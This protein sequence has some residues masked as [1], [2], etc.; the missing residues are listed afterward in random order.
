MDVKSKSAAGS[1]FLSVNW[2]PQ[3][4]QP[5][6]SGASALFASRQTA[7]SQEHR[8]SFFLDLSKVQ[9]KSPLTRRRG[10]TRTRSFTR[11]PDISPAAEPTMTEAVVKPKVLLSEYEYSTL[12]QLLCDRMSPGDVGRLS[13]EQ[14]GRF[15]EQAISDLDYLNSLAKKGVANSA[16]V[17][18]LI[19]KP[20][21]HKFF[22]QQDSCNTLLEDFQ[23][24]LKVFKTNRKVAVDR[25]I[26]VSL[27]CPDKRWVVTT[28]NTNAVI[29]MKKK[30]ASADKNHGTMAI[31]NACPV[32]GVPSHIPCPCCAEYAC[33]Y[34]RRQNTG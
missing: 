4:P 27:E 33:Q 19:R 3:L 24:H 17:P 30:L 14:L 15:C 26:S 10:I 16:K 22:D 8:P 32:S 11:L 23:K 6:D 34:S 2:Q 25:G 21:V 20:V 13:P 31:G 12:C 29:E 9:D 5:K 7:L 1:Q 28:S 18:A